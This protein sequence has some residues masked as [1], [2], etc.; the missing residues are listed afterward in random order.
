MHTFFKTG[1]CY[2]MFVKLIL[3]VPVGVCPIIHHVLLFTSSNMVEVEQ[4]T[5]ELESSEES[6]IMDVVNS[7]REK[8]RELC[9]SPPIPTINLNLSKLR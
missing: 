7:M 9:R 5:G 2:C 1:M 6:E 3:F 8:Q 4:F